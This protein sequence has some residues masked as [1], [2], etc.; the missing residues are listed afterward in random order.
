MG[1]LNPQKKSTTPLNE[2]EKE[3]A[4]IFVIVRHKL[5]LACHLA[6]AI[7]HLGT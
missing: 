2:N 6:K 7:R 4:R 5:V 1:Q 3:R